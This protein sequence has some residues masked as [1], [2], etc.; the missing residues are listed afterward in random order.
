MWIAICVGLL[1]AH[2][3]KTGYYKLSH[4]EHNSN[5]QST[6]SYLPIV[7]ECYI[8]FRLREI[9]RVENAV[10]AIGFTSLM[11]ETKALVRGVRAEFG[12]NEYMEGLDD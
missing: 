9:R 7:G 12:P 5:T 2:L 4:Y 6:P 10:M 1:I 3:C 8:Y 11:E